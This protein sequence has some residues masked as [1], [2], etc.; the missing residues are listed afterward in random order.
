MPHKKFLKSILILCVLCT[1]CGFALT[2][3]DKQG[4][5]Q[6]VTELKATL[7]KAQSL[8]TSVDEQIKQFEAVV[9]SGQN[10]L[11]DP[12]IPDSMKPSIQQ[13]FDVAVDKLATLKLYKTKIEMAVTQYQKV[14][15]SALADANNIGLE[16]EI[17]TYGGLAMSTAPYLPPP[18]NGYVYLGGALATVLAGF[19]AAK[20]KKLTTQVDE[21]KKT[22]TEIVISVDKLLSSPAVPDAELAKS[23]LEKAQSGST[24]NVVDAIHQPAR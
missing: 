20:N 16:Q 24:Q 1:L 3:C 19:F 15:D 5:A 4:S 18:Y 23:V 10:M 11:L 2:G 21:S 7:D 12:N 14:L 6:R 9:A 13:A 22:I 17:Q 8:S